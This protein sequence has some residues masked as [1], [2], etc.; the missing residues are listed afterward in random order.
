MVQ[1]KHGQLRIVETR[2]HGIN[3]RLDGYKY[4]P[5]F[6]I[7]DNEGRVSCSFVGRKDAEAALLEIRRSHD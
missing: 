2:Q 1:N 4:R 5:L 3:Y 7:C 6:Y